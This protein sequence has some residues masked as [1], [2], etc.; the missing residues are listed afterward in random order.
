LRTVAGKYT[1][2]QFLKGKERGGRYKV[3]GKSFSGE[4]SNKSGKGKKNFPIKKGE[5][6]EM[7]SKEDR[8]R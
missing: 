1:L 7:G 2:K 5:V 8:K 4:K 3:G 6:D